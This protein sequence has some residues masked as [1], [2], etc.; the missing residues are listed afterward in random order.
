MSSAEQLISHRCQD[1]FLNGCMLRQ[2]KGKARKGWMLFGIG[3][4][5]ELPLLHI[6]FPMNGEAIGRKVIAMQ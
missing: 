1:Y 5:N 6:G 2:R 4:S 3:M